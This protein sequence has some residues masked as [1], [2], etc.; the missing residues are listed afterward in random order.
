M[1]KNPEIIHLKH[2]Q[3]NY[4]KWDACLERAENKNMYARS[5]FLNIVSPQ[6]EALIYGDYRYIMPLPVKKRFRLTAIFQPLH[7]QQLG[8]FPPPRDQELQ[9]RFCQRLFRRS[10]VIHY[11]FN[12]SIPFRAF[13]K[14]K[15]Q[16]KTNYLLPPESSYQQHFKKFS[17]NARR[18]IKKA[19]KM[20][21]RVETGLEPHEFFRWKTQAVKRK[22]PAGSGPVLSRLMD[23]TLKNGKGSS[24][25]A[26]DKNNTLCAA[27]FI[28]FE[29]EKAYYLNAYSSPQGFKN[30][31]MYLIVSEL[32][33]QCSSRNIL[34]DFE[35]S[36]I[37]GVA[38][39]YKGF[40]AVPEIYFYT[41]TPG[42]PIA[43]MKN[44]MTRCHD[45]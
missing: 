2:Q 21:V 22:I 5:W 11:Q 39:F 6:W 35:G 42:N 41:Y 36:M 28:V 37:P 31:A 40:G 16:E 27:A 3:I 8:I 18:N 13:G 32:I 15:V 20:K 25:A 45:A 44:R 9:I 12:A 4:R 30:S 29:G 34:L 10:P 23:Q 24:Y 14:L 19:E 7:C 26:Y 33:K 38:R 43:W 1:S 17:E